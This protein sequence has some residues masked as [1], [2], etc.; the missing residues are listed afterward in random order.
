MSLLPDRYPK[1][2]PRLAKVYQDFV[3][4]KHVEANLDMGI[5]RPTVQKTN[6]YKKP[7]ICQC[8]SLKKLSEPRVVYWQHIKD[9]DPQNGCSGPDQPATS[10][11]LSAKKKCY[12]DPCSLNG[13]SHI[14][15]QK[16]SK[17][18]IQHLWCRYPYLQAMIYHS[19]S[20]ASPPPRPAQLA[21]HLPGLWALE[22]RIKLEELELA[23][24]Q[25]PHHPHP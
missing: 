9:I 21:K 8:T 3:R 18:I 19:K 10:L 7:Q 23:M 11:G 24:A 4:K 12:V 20:V 5:F 16:R 22:K 14:K 6:M 13:W 1:T 2:V 15:I 25:T 17:I